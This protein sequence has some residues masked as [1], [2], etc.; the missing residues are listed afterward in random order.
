MSAFL[1]PVSS[2]ER[3]FWEPQHASDF[4]FLLVLVLL[5]FLFVFG[6]KILMYV[7]QAGLKLR[8]FPASVSQAGFNIMCHDTWLAILNRI[9]IFYVKY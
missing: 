7:D 8:G 4:C 9:F 6:T 2:V 3:L 1:G 5:F